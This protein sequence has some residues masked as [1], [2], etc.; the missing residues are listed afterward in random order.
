MVHEADAPVASDAEAALDGLGHADP[1]A[2]A[3]AGALRTALAP[4]EPYVAPSDVSAFA[5]PDG[6]TVLALG[7]LRL[8]ALHAPGHTPGSVLYLVDE[9]VLTGDVLFAGSVGRTDLP[10]GD[11]PAMTR[12]LRDVVGRL[13]TGLTVLPGHGPATTVARELA[14]NPYL[15]SAL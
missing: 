7:A 15:R 12:T 2:S 4:T 9:V 6:E 5:T 11:P 3:V 14:T 8:R 13:D 10:G 1:A